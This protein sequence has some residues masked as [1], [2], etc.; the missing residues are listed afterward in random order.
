VTLDDMVNASVTLIEAYQ[1][2]GGAYPAG[3]GY[4]TYRYCWL[5]DGSFIADA[6]S[7]AGRLDSAEAFFGW[8]ARVLRSRARHVAGVVTRARGG[9]QVP[10]ALLLP[11]RYELDGRDGVEPWENFQLDGYGTWL[12]ALVEHGQRHGR[13]IDGYLDAIGTTVDYLA[14]FGNRPC[15][16]WWEENPDERH[17]ST[18]AAVAAGLR[19]AVH[20]GLLTPERVAAAERMAT[21]VQRMVETDAARTGYLTKWLGSEAVD[22]SLL[23]CLVPYGTVPLDSPVARTTV[24]RIRGELTPAGVYR[25]LGDTFYGGGE[26]LILTAWL[27]W[28]ELVT[29]DLASARH[30]LEWI[31]AQSTVDGLLPEQVLAHAQQPD[32]IAEWQRRWGPVATPLLWSHAMFVTVALATREAAA[33]R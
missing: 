7:R 22:G 11:T 6:M 29:G 10:D 33:P 18:L 13:P 8:C 15:F 21:E 31:V 32:F 24:E 3:P 9:E 4:P 25:Y 23:A 30:R 20:S 19:A 1:D 27:G 17:T 16:D 12:W 5:R 2:P 14:T 28:Y 26:W